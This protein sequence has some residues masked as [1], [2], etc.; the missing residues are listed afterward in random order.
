MGKIKVLEN[1]F[2]FVKKPTKLGAK[3]VFIEIPADVRSRID[4]NT[5]YLIILVPLRKYHAKELLFIE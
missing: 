4:L 1:L 5:E 2:A 3:R